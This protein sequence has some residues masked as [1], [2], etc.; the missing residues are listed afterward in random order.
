M[1]T[2]HDDQIVS[3]L[4]ELIIVNELLRKKILEKIKKYISYF[5][6][7]DYLKPISYIDFLDFIHKNISDFSS[8]LELKQ[9]FFNLELFIIKLYRLGEISKKDINNTNVRKLRQAFAHRKSSDILL[10]KERL[11]IF[12]SLSFDLNMFYVTNIG[13]ENKESEI[14][15]YNYFAYIEILSII[16]KENFK[17][18]IENIKQLRGLNDNLIKELFP[19]I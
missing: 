6:N 10:G 11:V 19:E 15:E 18:K 12:I 17:N 8:E 7:F 14:I 2:I 4:L 1:E 9:F 5:K 16:F 3:E 13:S